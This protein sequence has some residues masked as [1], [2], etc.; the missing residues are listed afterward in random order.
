MII[1]TNYPPEKA[2]DVLFAEPIVPIAE[3]HHV[4]DIS[5]Q[6]VPYRDEPS[7][8]NIAKFAGRMVGNVIANAMESPTLEQ[9]LEIGR[10]LFENYNTSNFN[11]APLSVFEA[12]FE[13][14]VELVIRP[15]IGVHA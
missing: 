5:G 7:A 8:Q 1:F 2:G 14:G 15:E 10:S 3:A 6:R 12:G 4:A 13:E 9:A 11:F